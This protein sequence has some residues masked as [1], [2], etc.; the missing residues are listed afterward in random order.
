MR[1]IASHLLLVEVSA[2]AQ[3]LF[4]ALPEGRFFVRTVGWTDLESALDRA[5]PGTILL[6]E[7]IDGSGADGVFE[8]IEAIRTLLTTSP[9]M[10]VV[11]ISR[12]P[13][14]AG[15]IFGSLLTSGLTEWID[16]S[17]EGSLGAVERRLRYAAG[18]VVQRLLN[19]ALP[20][21]LP[22]RT[23]S[24]LGVAAEVAATGGYMKEFADYM[25]VA[26]RT[27]SRWCGRADLPPPRR[28]LAWLR[29]LLVADH[30]DSGGR[31]LE[32]IARATGYSSAA[33]VKTALR[34]MMGAT[35]K[36]LREAGAFS[37]VAR[38]F[39]ADLRKHREARHAR[40][41]PARQWLN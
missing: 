23:R 40:G 3:R 10:P 18:V 24:L 17:R 28:L 35:P 5:H 2:E 29:A 19:R 30:L 1:R 6:T 26:D 13:E 20:G 15:E 36:Q 41:R 33:S 34:N 32:S 16:L 31:T 38:A 14:N 37:S 11:A 27:L 8:R 7:P 21:P 39:A 25:G 22:S 4:C 9:A 12:H